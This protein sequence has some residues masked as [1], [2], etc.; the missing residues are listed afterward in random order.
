MPASHDE[1]RRTSNDNGG[2]MLEVHWDSFVRPA[3]RRGASGVSENCALPGGETR[4]AVQGP[5]ATRTAIRAMTDNVTPRPVL[6]RDKIG[7]LQL[8]CPRAC[9]GSTA[10]WLTVGTDTSRR[11]DRLDSWKEI[12][13]YLNRSVRTLHRWEKDEGLPVHRHQHKELGS[14]FAYKRELDAWIGARSPDPDFQAQDD[15]PAS[16]PRSRLT[17]ALTLAAAAFVIGAIAYLVVSRSRPEAAQGHTPVAGLEL[18]STFAGSHRWPSLSPD[19]RMMAFVSDAAGTPQVWVKTLG[20][21]VPIQ[22]TFGD[23]PAVRPRWSAHRRPHHLFGAGRRHLVR[24]A[25][26]RRIPPD[27]GARLERGAL[28]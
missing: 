2:T 12:A 23:L 10:F 3:R 9:N 8:L 13:A 19:G 14:V 6:V 20:S 4:S 26:G 5:Q 17:V 15:Q 25:A 1:Q 21:G 28:A 18:I 24:G 7:V 27:R 16:A 22:I 11:E